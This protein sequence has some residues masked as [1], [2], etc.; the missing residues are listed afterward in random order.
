MSNT[1]PT[2]LPKDV[3]KKLIKVREELVIGDINEAY[4]H[5]YSIIDPEFMTF[6]PWDKI[7]KFIDD[8][9]E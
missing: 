6:D 5:L 8:K 4:H 7:E 1:D 9:N 2:S 3:L